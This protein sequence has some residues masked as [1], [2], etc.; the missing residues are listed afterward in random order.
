VAHNAG[1]FWPRRG[2]LKRQGTI[3]VIVGKPI[4]TANRDPRE[5][6]AEVRAWIEAEIAAMSDPFR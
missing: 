5:L 4:P 6:N 1:H 2:L 3:D